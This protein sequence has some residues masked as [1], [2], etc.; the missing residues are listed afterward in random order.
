MNKYSQ[1]NA[2]RRYIVLL[3]SRDLCKRYLFTEKRLASQTFPLI[4]TLNDIQYSKRQVY[5]IDKEVLQVLTVV[6]L[7]TFFRILL[8]PC[9]L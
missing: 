4:K 6:L 1:R 9:S 8:L 5:Y 3:V 2:Q 7:K